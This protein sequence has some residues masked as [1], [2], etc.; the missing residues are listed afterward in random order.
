MK[1]G[2]CIKYGETEVGTTTMTLEREAAMVVF[3][4]V[5]AEI[6]QTRGE[7]YLEVETTRHLLHIVEEAAGVGVQVDV[8]SYAAA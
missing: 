7:A 8:R 2:V 3:K 6:C 1:C 5:P 4:H